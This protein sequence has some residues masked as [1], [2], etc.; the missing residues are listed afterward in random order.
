MARGEPQ[1]EREGEGCGGGEIKKKERVN[2]IESSV[3]A[4][5]LCWR[6]EWKDKGSVVSSNYSRD[7]S[8]LQLKKQIR[9][10][11]HT[12]TQTHKNRISNLTLAKVRYGHG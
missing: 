10:L 6:E 2:E 3:L 11:A 7:T 8:L 4:W 5:L 9:Q 12:Y 1:A